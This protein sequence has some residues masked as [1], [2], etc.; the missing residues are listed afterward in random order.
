[1]NI[2]NILFIIV[3]NFYQGVIIVRLT[4]KFFLVVIGTHE[5]TPIV[6]D[7]YPTEEEIFNQI[8]KQ[9]GKT[10]RVEKRFVITPNEGAEEIKM[11][12]KLTY[13]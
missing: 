2:Q 3:I 13:Y 5:R 11:S 9:D 6:Y 4:E 1:M 10:A 8:I 12:D 7:R